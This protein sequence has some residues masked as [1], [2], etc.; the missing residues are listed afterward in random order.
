MEVKNVR[1]L[2]RV[3][4]DFLWCMLGVFLGSSL[5]EYYDYVHHKGLYEMNSAPWYTGI[6]TSGCL[7]AV[8]AAVLPIIMFFLKRRIRK[9]SQEKVSADTKS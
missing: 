4:R 1:K 8:L 7:V 2:Y 3:L 9:Q 6:L 5:Y